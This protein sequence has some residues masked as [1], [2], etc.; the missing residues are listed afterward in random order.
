MP[1]A[2]ALRFHNFGAEIRLGH[3]DSRR[4]HAAGV[5]DL[6]RQYGPE[7]V[8]DITKASSAH[9]FGADYIACILR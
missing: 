9:A 7:P 3:G 8:A 4:R 1:G 2:L 6:I 5:L